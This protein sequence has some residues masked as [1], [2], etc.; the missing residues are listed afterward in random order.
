MPE[1][2]AIWNDRNQFAAEAAKINVWISADSA[3]GSP[4]QAEIVP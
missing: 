3:H 2:F 4:A 1:A